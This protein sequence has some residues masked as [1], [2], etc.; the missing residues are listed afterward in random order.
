MRRSAQRQAEQHAR[1]VNEVRKALAQAADEGQAIDEAALHRA[2][3]R[4]SGRG[5]YAMRMTSPLTAHFGTGSPT[6]G[7]PGRQQA[8]D[9]GEAHGGHWERDIDSIFSETP[10]TE[11]GWSPDFERPAADEMWDERRVGSHRRTRPR[12]STAETMSTAAGEMMPRPHS[13]GRRSF[14]TA[15]SRPDTPDTWYGSSQKR[16]VG[17]AGRRPSARRLHAEISWDARG[18]T[19]RPQ[20]AAARRPRPEEPAPGPRRERRRPQSAAARSATLSRPYSGRRNARRR[21]PSSGRSSSGG[22]QRSTSPSRP[23]LVLEDPLRRRDDH[24]RGRISSRQ[25]PLRSARRRGASRERHSSIDSSSESPTRVANRRPRSSTA[26]SAAD[27][28]FSDDDAEDEVL[29]VMPLPLD[30]PIAE[31]DEDLGEGS[32]APTEEQA[33]GTSIPVSSDAHRGDHEDEGGRR[34][35]VGSR[36]MRRRPHTAPQSRPNPQSRHGEAA[37]Q[38]RTA[39]AHQHGVPGDSRPRTAMPTSPLKVYEDMTWHGAALEAKT[40][41][42]RS[43]SSARP[44]D[45]GYPKTGASD[46]KYDKRFSHLSP[47]ITRSTYADKPEYW[48]ATGACASPPPRAQRKHGAAESQSKL[49]RRRPASA[50][51]SS[52]RSPS[53]STPSQQVERGH[54]T[55]ATQR[56]QS[57]L[58][59]GGGNRRHAVESTPTGHAK[60]R[61]TVGTATSRRRASAVPSY[62]H[63]GRPAESR[64]ARMSPAITEFTVV[65]DSGQQHLLRLMKPR[66]DGEAASAVLDA[67]RSKSVHDESATSVDDNIDES[68]GA[69]TGTAKRHQFPAAKDLQVPVREPESQSRR[70]TATVGQPGRSAQL[71][72]KKNIVAARGERK[73][74]QTSNKEARSATLNTEATDDRDPG[75]ASSEAASKSST[76]PLTRKFSGSYMDASETTARARASPAR[77][78]SR[79]SESPRTWPVSAPDKPKHVSDDEE[80]AHPLPRQ[81]VDWDVPARASRS[82]SFIEWTQAVVPDLNPFAVNAAVRTIQEAW[83]RY[84]IKKVFDGVTSRAQ[85]E[86]RMEARERRRRIARVHL[87]RLGFDDAYATGGAGG[88]PKN[89]AIRRARERLFI[90]DRFRAWAEVTVPQAQARKANQA[91]SKVRKCVNAWRL[92]RTIHSRV[93]FRPMLH[94]AARVIQVAFREHRQQTLSLKLRSASGVIAKALRHVFGSVI[95]RRWDTVRTDVVMAMELFGLVVE[96]ADARRNQALAVLSRAIMG[97]WLRVR[98]AKGIAKRAAVRKRKALAFQHVWAKTDKLDAKRSAMMM[99][100]REMRASIVRIRRDEAAHRRK[101]RVV[102]KQMSALHA[103]QWRARAESLAR[104][105]QRVWRGRVGR[106]R[107]EHVRDLT[108]STA[109]GQEAAARRVQ[110]GYKEYRR[111][112]RVWRYRRKLRVKIARGRKQDYKG[113][114][115][116]YFARSVSAV[117]SKRYGRVH[118]QARRDILRARAARTLQ[119]NMR[120]VWLRRA[121]VA[122]SVKERTVRLLVR[123]LDDSAVAIQRVYRDYAKRK[124]AATQL[125]QRLARGYSARLFAKGKRR[126]RNQARARAELQRK[127]AILA[128]YKRKRAVQLGRMLWY[129]VARLVVLAMRAR[130]AVHY[131]S[132][133][134]RAL[135]EAEYN[136]AVRLQK[137]WRARQARMERRKQWKEELSRRFRAEYTIFA[138]SKGK[139]LDLSTPD[140]ALSITELLRRKLPFSKALEVGDRVSARWMGG[141]QEHLAVVRSIDMAVTEEQAAQRKAE[142]AERQKR[143]IVEGV[144]AG[145]SEAR[146]ESEAVDS[147][148]FTLVYQDGAVEHG[149]KREWITFR[150]RPRFLTEREALDFDVDEKVAPTLSQSLK[151]PIASFKHVVE[152]ARERS[153]YRSRMRAEIVNAQTSG[154]PNVAPGDGVVDIRIIVGEHAN[155]EFESDQWRRLRRGKRRYVKLWPDLRA[156]QRLTRSDTTSVHVWTLNGGGDRV[157]SDLRIVRL[158]DVYES[159]PPP[160]MAALRE[161]GYAVLF[162]ANAPTADLWPAPARPSAKERPPLPIAIVGAFA[163]PTVPP[164][165]AIRLSSRRTVATWKTGGRVWSETENFTDGFSPLPEDLGLFKLDPGSRVWCRWGTCKSETGTDGQPLPARARSR[166][167]RRVV[168]IDAKAQR[169]YRFKRDPRQRPDEAELAEAM[170]DSDDYFRRKLR[171]VSSGSPGSAK[172]TDRS[173]RAAR[174]RGA[175]AAEEDKPA[176][177]GGEAGELVRSATFSFPRRRVELLDNTELQMRDQAEM[178]GGAKR[179]EEQPIEPKEVLA[180]ATRRKPPKA[181]LQPRGSEVD[182]DAPIALDGLHGGIVDTE[183]DTSATSDDDSS[184]SSSSEE[185]KPDARW[186]E[187]SESEDDD[188]GAARE[189]AMAEANAEREKAQGVYKGPLRTRDNFSARVRDLHFKDVHWTKF[190]ALYR[191]LQGDST[192]VLLSDIESAARVTVDLGPFRAQL[193]GLVEEKPDCNMGFNLFV[194]WCCAYCTSPPTETLQMVYRA[195]AGPK[196]FMTKLDLAEMIATLHPEKSEVKRNQLLSVSAGIC[197]LATDESQL[198][199]DIFARLYGQLSSLFFPAFQM[200]IEVQRLVLGE[201]FWATVQRQEAQRVKEKRSAWRK[202]QKKM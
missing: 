175:S 78:R 100:Y 58:P 185:S 90:R 37:E 139:K 157:L 84:E 105:L 181:K 8:W 15:G 75:H 200:R 14:T 126:E 193:M 152:K 138:A 155:E 3:A 150:E 174:G 81:A 77:P 192:G 133:A 19:W 108:L 67:S 107:F 194:E 13:G 161:A 112:L 86:L 79:G 202:A 38:L 9:D 140:A 171:S 63:S 46:G 48:G 64:I 18:K 104:H 124:L 29:D 136:A 35:A 172:S 184:T 173:E 197:K 121:L 166:P 120:R 33:S 72:G 169:E 145:E 132:E 2:A 176:P 7:S 123:Q 4:R 143:E 151:H 22:R 53:A 156:S 52:G 147:A 91:A 130:W 163:K 87:R 5:S 129:C 69:A 30:A 83:A 94:T 32:G 191:S 179:D 93:K 40:S 111:R 113:R 135:W 10:L 34:T 95:R 99:L 177:A 142:I 36:D 54:V 50:H 96:A 1:Q 88:R 56:P 122:A 26:D 74:A 164:I 196:G 158:E 97:W 28:V 119:R 65:D 102:L 165:A 60:A 149:V 148:T 103:A 20:S 66:V 92:R 180:E 82:Q 137:N 23:Y 71:L 45:R 131:R 70:H 61:T 195:F 178:L 190:S 146:F 11:A 16:G 24:G 110:A 59:G 198:S 51:P 42:N 125:M 134:Q 170:D 98:V 182:Y 12:S 159:P 160:Y 183:S 199:Y 21:R 80:E 118:L 62:R 154:M 109:L 25:R 89:E 189:L 17:G 117:S 6:R 49:Q 127:A 144:M 55:P 201:R 114:R 57:A 162:R 128:A 31:V 153:T 115:G 76:I 106:R 44:D 68:H 186:I 101:M 39:G 27:F 43:K 168:Q 47:E 85:L 73:R 167:V 116:R 188:W 141:V 41:P 187:E